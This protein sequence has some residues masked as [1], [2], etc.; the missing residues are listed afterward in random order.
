MGGSPDSRSYIYFPCTCQEQIFHNNIYNT[1][2]MDDSCVRNT[3]LSP[4]GVNAIF[5]DLLKFRL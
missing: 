2:I 3:A 4:G 5:R 1:L